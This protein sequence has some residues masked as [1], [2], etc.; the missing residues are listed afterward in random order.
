LTGGKKSKPGRALTLVERGQDNTKEGV[1]TKKSIRSR[2]SFK[3]NKCFLGSSPE[4]MKVNDANTARKR[5]GEACRRVGSEK[6]TRP[7]ARREGENEAKGPTLPWPKRR[8]FLFQGK[9][10]V[11]GQATSRTAPIVGEPEGGKSC[12]AHRTPRCK[13]GGRQISGRNNSLGEGKQMKEKGRKAPCNVRV[14]P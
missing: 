8:R 3:P 12:A 2:R 11:V 9:N 6:M 7:E 5:K 13:K 4:G 14:N 1:A 10:R